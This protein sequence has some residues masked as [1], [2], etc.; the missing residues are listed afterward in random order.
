MFMAL[1]V[2]I[3]QFLGP[4]NSRLNPVLWASN[5]QNLQKLFAFSIRLLL[6]LLVKI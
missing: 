6:N 5:K 4:V 1:A 3:A 2:P